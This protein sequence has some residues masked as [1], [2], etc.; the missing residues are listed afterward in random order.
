MQ[1]TDPRALQNSNVTAL[2]QQ[3]VQQE[4]VVIRDPMPY[5]DD[6]MDPRRS[7]QG[8]AQPAKPPSGLFAH[9][10][11]SVPVE[12]AAV[13]GNGESMTRSLFQHATGLF[14]KRPMSASTPEVVVRRREPLATESV[15]V[16]QA[17]ELVMEPE[18][19]PIERRTMALDE[20][21]LDIPAFLRRQ[22]S[23]A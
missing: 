1:A 13:Q 9:A 22:S 10:P 12:T 4:R 21:G 19:R 7:V 3:T 2:R 6:P 5:P 18:Q 17:T 14:R 11:G 8:N 16:L 23:S 15:H 20:S